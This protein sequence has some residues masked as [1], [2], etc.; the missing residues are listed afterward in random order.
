MEGD[1][2]GCGGGGRE[3]KEGVE[4][5]GDEDIHHHTLAAAATAVVVA[6]AAG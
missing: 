1:G 2:E 6:A 4:A 3:G 5:T